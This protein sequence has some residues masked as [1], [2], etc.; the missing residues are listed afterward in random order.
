MPREG[1]PGAWV[2]L[3]FTPYDGRRIEPLLPCFQ[4]VSGRYP[5]PI[6]IRPISISKPYPA[7]PVDHRTN[8]DLVSQ[9]LLCLLCH[10]CCLYL[11]PTSWYKNT[12][13]YVLVWICILNVTLP[14][15][16]GKCKKTRPPNPR[17]NTGMRAGF[18]TFLPLCFCT[19]VLCVCACV[20]FIV[21]FCLCGCVT[22]SQIFAKNTKSSHFCPFR[23][24]LL[25]DV[26]GSI[27][28]YNLQKVRRANT[29][30]PLGEPFRS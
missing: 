13:R 4:P 6:R 21:L 22:A 9:L 18:C 24:I 17:R 16:P 7:H 1:N 30:D 26:K 27:N 15:E 3:R 14:P 28:P 20:L 19:C 8:C 2:D 5:Y 23:T 11:A 12:N 10:N 29:K 25:L